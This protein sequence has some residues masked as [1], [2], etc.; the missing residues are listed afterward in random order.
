[1]KNMK[2][3]DMFLNDLKILVKCEY[4]NNPDGEYTKG[5]KNGSLNTLKIIFGLLREKMPKRN[6]KEK[7]G[8]NNNVVFPCKP[9]HEDE[10]P[11][12]SKYETPD[13]IKFIK[14]YA[15]KKKNGDVND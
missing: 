9:T 8:I 11:E 2:N 7:E 3:Y 15:F 6:K 10:F 4:E 12:D 1:M 5:L 13:S 14:N